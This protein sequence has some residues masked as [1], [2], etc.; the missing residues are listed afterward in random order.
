MKP[1]RPRWLRTDLYDIDDPSCRDPEQVE[2][3][4]R[5]LA[6]ALRWWFRPQVRGLDRI[7]RG[8]CLF[9][10]NHNAALLMPEIYLFC[11]SL[12]ERDGIEGL[13]YGLGHSLGLQLPLL[14]CLLPPLG[15]IR[16]RRAL[17]EELLL[18]GR[19]L[20]VY[21]GGEL[22]SMRPSRHRDRVVFGR[23][24]GY[25]KLAIRA[26]VPLVPVVTSGAHET[27]YI[28]DDGRWL[29][30]WLGLDRRLELK[31]WPIV[32]C[33]PWGLWLGVPPPHLPWRT[34]IIQEVLPP[35]RLPW[36]GPAAADDRDHV[37]AC[38]RLVIRRMERA[39]RRLSEERT[40]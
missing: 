40:A 36:I 31:T 21:P 2:A 12:Y 11:V 23:R 18:Q 29:A 22:D 25:L 16:G 3:A 24:R 37:E 4:Y 8:G 17:A 9:V 7:P 15:A 35:V 5:R 27:L 20:L 38:H 28:L 34:R 39:L 19:R 14:H 6:P 30:R 1:R 33:L 13:P 32:L 10:G 26:G